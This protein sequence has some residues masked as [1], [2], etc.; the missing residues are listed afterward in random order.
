M[1]TPR[2]DDRPAADGV[3][4]RVHHSDDLDVSGRRA[5]GRL[6][7]LRGRFGLVLPLAGDDLHHRGTSEPDPR[8]DA[9]VPGRG[10]QPAGAAVRLGERDPRTAVRPVLRRERQRRRCVVPRPAGAALGRVPGVPDLPDRAGDQRS[11]QRPDCRDGVPV[12]QRQHRHLDV[13]LRRLP[14]VLHVLPARL[15]LRVHTDRQVGR[16]PAVRRQ[17]RQAAAVPRRC[18]LV[19]AHRTDRRE[20]VGLHRRVD[21]GAGALLAGVHLR[22][23]RDRVHPHPGD[24]H[25]A[26][27]P[28]R[29][30]RPLRLD[31]DHRDRRRR[32]ERAVLHRPAR[33]ARV[34]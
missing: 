8:P 9:Q 34:P 33:A 31:L 3:R 21:G 11:A 12:L 27:P 7:H 17:L 10:D 29:L 18:P 2:L 5:L 16:P 24:A 30:I 25:R 15:H 1:A 32:H 14:V 4:P 26:D 20:V 28:G 22:D 19:P 13:R 23:C 6:V